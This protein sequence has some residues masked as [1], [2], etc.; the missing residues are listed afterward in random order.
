MDKLE[1]IELARIVDE[2]KEQSEIKVDT[3]D[4]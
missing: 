4:L 2:R 1:D 3:D